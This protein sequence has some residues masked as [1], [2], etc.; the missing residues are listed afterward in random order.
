[1]SDPEILKITKKCKVDLTPGKDRSWNLIL[2]EVDP[3]CIEALQDISN[4]MGTESRKFLDKRLIPG[5]LQIQEF[6]EQLNLKKRKE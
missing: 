1:M 3:I 2:K 5:S 6:L 4:K